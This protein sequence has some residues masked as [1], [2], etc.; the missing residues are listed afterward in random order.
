MNK[1][2][3]H[4]ISRLRQ[5]ILSGELTSGQRLAEIPTAEQLGVS[6]TP[7]RIAFRTLEQ[8]GLLTKLS[9]RG[10]IVRQVT[11]AEI[12]GSVEVRGVL[13]GLAARQ[14]AE[15]TL[16]KDQADELVQLL[17]QGD[18]LFAKGSISEQDLAIYHDMNQ[19]F[20]Q[21]IIAASLN[22]AIA[23]ALSRNEHLPFASVSALAFDRNNLTSEY[24]RFNFAHMQH[25]AVFDAISHGQ[26]SRAEAIMREHANA[27][28]GYA[29]T[30]S[31]M[32]EKGE[33]VQVINGL[34]AIDGH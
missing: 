2:G 1:P 18:D 12:S 30:F 19:R 28:L 4:V 20:H 13:E 33:K 5:M 27:T 21:I 31:Q 9:G 6:R 17:K 32:K 10:Y 11:Q 16:S 25:H 7:V 22:P 24:R 8:E 15:N 23:E 14:A 34:N 29:K 26:G 3:Q